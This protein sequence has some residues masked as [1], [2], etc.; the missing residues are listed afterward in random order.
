MKEKNERK[1]RVKYGQRKSAGKLALNLSEAEKQRSEHRWA[2]DRPG[3][4]A[5]L[6]DAGYERVTTDVEGGSVR[7]GGS[8]AN[9]DGMKMVLMR[10][11]RE[12][13][14]EDAKA[15]KAERDALMSQVKESPLDRKARQDVSDVSG[16]HVQMS[17]E[18]L[19]IG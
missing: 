2:S 19:E 14:D 6:E 4:I 17:E 10:T 12:F 11:P 8:H 13:Y 1:E 7:H 18:R 9:G 5:E 15:K 16:D 3:R